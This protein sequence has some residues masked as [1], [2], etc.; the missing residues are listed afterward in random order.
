MYAPGEAAMVECKL[1]HCP[2]SA[3]LRQPP[4][5]PSPILRDSCKGEQ[6][7]L[8]H[9]AYHIHDSRLCAAAAGVAPPLA[10]KDGRAER[11]C[12][13]WRL[14]RTKLAVKALEL[15]LEIPVDAY[16]FIDALP[17]LFA[18]G[19]GGG[20]SDTR[21]AGALRLCLVC[22]VGDAQPDHRS[23][24]AAPGIGLRQN[25]HKGSRRGSL[26]GGCRRRTK[27][28]DWRTY[29]TFAGCTT[30]GSVT[31]VACARRRGL[32]AIEL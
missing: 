19:G 29:I 23:V 15:L 10:R 18:H 30:P 27:L 11:S 6:L 13:L 16:A 25:R 8:A 3:H 9:S 22:C 12:V 2:R 24:P 20:C 32:V 28:W 31:C 21:V 7:A 1:A 17:G 14:A 4:S 26:C 5:P